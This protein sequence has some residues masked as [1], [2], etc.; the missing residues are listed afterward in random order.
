MRAIQAITRVSES[1]ARRL[2]KLRA[3]VAGVLGALTLAVTIGGPVQAAEFKLSDEAGVTAGL[4]L[5]TSFTSTEAGAG[6]GIDRSKN[7]AAESTRLFF[8]GHYGKVIKG[9]LNFEKTGAGGNTDNVLDAY[10]GFEF[11][12]AFNIWFGHF[13]PPQD[14][15]NGYGPYYATPWDFPLLV[16]RYPNIQNGRDDGVAFWGK[17]LNNKL[18]WAGG[19]FEGN[20]GGAGT[21][22][23]AK[24]DLAFSGRLAYNIWDPEPAP[25]YLSGGWYG[26][27]K[28]ILTVGLGAFTQKNG[29]GTVATPSDLDI[30]NLDVLFE[31]KFSMGVPTLEG[32]YY[33]YKANVADAVIIPGKAYLVGAAFLFP[34][35]VGWGQFQPFYR[36]QSLKPDS[37]VLPGTPEM[38]KHDF[39]VNYIIKGPNAKISLQYSKAE[40]YNYGF[41]GPSAPGTERDQFVI[42]AQLV[43]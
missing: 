34:A 36:Y 32:A 28:D 39:G 9:T 3:S 33:E 27:S 29:V 25:A 17:L 2:H 24:H 19:I 20:R 31:K 22:T 43:Y 35:K 41:A 12:D 5:R 26:G 7:F 16:S 18:V 37:S 4:G 10:V 8:S 30:W 21:A 13:L 42:G 23:F 38:K 14:R 6:N 1:K 40:N 15:G 11:S